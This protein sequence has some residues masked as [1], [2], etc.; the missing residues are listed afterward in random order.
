MIKELCAAI[1]AAWG[2]LWLCAGIIE[3]LKTW[4]ESL[5]CLCLACRRR[6]VADR[7]REGAPEN[8]VRRENRFDC[9]KK[10]IAE[11]SRS[12]KKVTGP[13]GEVAKAISGSSR[14]R[15]LSRVVPKQGRAAEPTIK[16]S[17]SRIFRRR[18]PERTGPPQKRTPGTPSRGS[19]R[20]RARGKAPSRGVTPGKKVRFE[21]NLEGTVRAQGTDEGNVFASVE[22]IET[23]FR[24]WLCD[25]DVGPYT[26]SV[27]PN[28]QRIERYRDCGLILNLYNSN[29]G[30]SV[31]TVVFQGKQ[32]VNFRR[33]WLDSKRAY[34]ASLRD[35][36]K[37]PVA[38]IPPIPASKGR[39][40][41][42][43]SIGKPS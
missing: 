4:F 1:F 30:P 34:F 29:S 11:P 3:R 40:N 9:F 19:S 43:P 24:R 13:D 41:L 12:A 14:R 23:E 21:E 18:T 36:L 33:G 2:I 42:Y 38:K 22:V 8:A 16:R 5:K 6:G 32:G 35:R 27:G 17:P 15:S 26:A 7:R 31:T 37:A 28:G 20:G 39:E 25:Q 10:L